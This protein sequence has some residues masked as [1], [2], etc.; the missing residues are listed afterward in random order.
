M[1]T[2]ADDFNTYDEACIYYGVDTPAQVRAE[3]EADALEWAIA[4]LDDLEIKGPTV[5]PVVDYGDCPF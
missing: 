4:S 1:W 2:W 3:I 5:T